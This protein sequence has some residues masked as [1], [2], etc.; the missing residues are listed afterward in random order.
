MVQFRLDSRI[1]WYI[2]NDVNPDLAPC[3][4]FDFILVGYD[5]VFS[6]LFVTSMCHP[7]KFLQIKGI[8]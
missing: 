3:C 4:A 5:G 7:L 2:I 6:I 1:G 8:V